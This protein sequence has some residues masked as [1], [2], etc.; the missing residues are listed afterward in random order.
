MPTPHEKVC[1]DF[2]DAMLDIE[3]AIMGFDDGEHEMRAL[4]NAIAEALKIMFAAVGGEM[5]EP[6]Q[7]H[8]R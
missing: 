6:R 7:K 3:V 8:E 5:V 1:A 2:S 4:G